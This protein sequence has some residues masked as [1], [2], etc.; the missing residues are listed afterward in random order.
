MAKLGKFNIFKIYVV[1]I[2]FFLFLLRSIVML[3]KKKLTFPTILKFF[4]YNENGRKIME[5]AFSTVILDIFITY[6]NF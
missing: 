6:V 4:I 5:F 2:E 1:I 3:T